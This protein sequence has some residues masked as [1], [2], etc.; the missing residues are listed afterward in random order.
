MKYT[1]VTNLRWANPEGTLID[2]DVEF[3][4]LGPVP[5]TASAADS[6]PHSVE[7]FNRAVAGDFGPIAD[8]VPPPPH[9]PTVADVE[10]E[11]ARRLALGFDYDFADARGIHRI[12]TTDEDMEGWDEVTSWAN[13]MLALGNTTTTLTIVTDTGPADVTAQEW[14]S[15]LAAAAAFRQPIWGV[16]FQL[17]AMDPIPDDYAADKYWT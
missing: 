12:G 6:A 9:V 11:R 16:S 7:I 5:F 10:T 8:Y 15:V 4:S 13:A 3:A 1:S 2:C 17:A 14:Q